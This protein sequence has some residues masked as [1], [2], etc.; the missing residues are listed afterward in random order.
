MYL[1]TRIAHINCLA[2]LSLAFAAV[3]ASAQV[4]DLA[5]PPETYLGQQ[6]PGDWAGGTGSGRSFIF[7]DVSP[8]QLSSVDIEVNPSATTLFTASLYTI[9]G[10]KTLGSLLATNSTSLSDVGRAFY[11]IP[12]SRS[13]VGGNNRFLID[14]HWN[15]DPT[16]A[17]FYSFDGQG[18][19]QEGID[20]PYVRGP[21]RIIDG[22][23]GSPAGEDNYVI[24]HFRLGIVPEPASAGLF[25]L[26]S[27]ALFATA[28]RDSVEA[29]ALVEIDIA[30][31]RSSNRGACN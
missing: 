4:V 3:S 5:P 11:N 31:E 23:S 17:R 6:F 2:M 27:I 16:E 18:D 22:K 25:T 1:T 30:V 12:L 9:T 28:R 21:V 24:S 19:G 20:L 7:E 15:S 10:T 26:G 14:I 8:F 13:F 29:R